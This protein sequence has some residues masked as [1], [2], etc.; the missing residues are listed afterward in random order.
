METNS[1]NQKKDDWKPVCYQMQRLLEDELV[2]AELE[3]WEPGMRGVAVELPDGRRME[4]FFT[5]PMRDEKA[6]GQ[7]RVVPRPEDVCEAVVVLFGAVAG[8]DQ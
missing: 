6:G 5:L 3:P 4:A 2:N 7:V 8:K 1:T